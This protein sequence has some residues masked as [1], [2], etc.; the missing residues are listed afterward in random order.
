MH[1]RNGLTALKVKRKRK[2]GRYGDGG[3]LY[4]AVKD[5]GAKS[6]VFAWKRGGKRRLRGLGSTDDVTLAEA[7]ELATD[8]RRLVRQ[9]RDPASVRADRAGVPTFGDCARKLID[10]KEPGWRNAKHK[11]QWRA[12][13]LGEVP[14]GDGKPAKVQHDFAAGIRNMP[15]NEVSTAA[16]LAVL[17]PLWRSKTETATRL[18]QR[19]EAVLDFAKAHHHRDGENPARWRGHLDKILPPPEKVARVV[20]LT[21]MPYPEVPAFMA[22]LRGAEGV[23]ARALEFAILMA[24]RTGEVRGATWSEFDLS[25]KLWTV[26]GE[27]MKSEREHRVPLSGRAVDILEEMEKL[28]SSQFVFPG[29]RDGRPLSDMTLTAVLR[30]LGVDVTVHGFRSSFRDWAGD[31]TAFARDVVEASLAHVIEN[32][33]EAAYRRS[34]ALEKRRELMQAWAAYCKPKAANVVAMPRRT[35]VPRGGRPVG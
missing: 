19:I 16:V 14:R 25:L 32:K 10:A 33:T 7:R 35:D 31:C 15:V 3:G 21:A 11:Y 13:L 23:G 17:Q 12:T 24:A 2:P 22:K 5:S 27:R 4:L 9:G 30:R 8:C 20:H 29:F 26:P 1:K 34:D 18:R 28:R 6:W